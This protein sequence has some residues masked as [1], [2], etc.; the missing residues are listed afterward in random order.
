MLR[1]SSGLWGSRVMIQALHAA[2]AMSASCFE[3]PCSSSF[4]LSRDVITS[5]NSPIGQLCRLFV[6]FESGQS[7]LDLI[8]VPFWRPD[9]LGVATHTARSRPLPRLVA[10]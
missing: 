8:L 2:S 7:G 1:S 3:R 10:A 5:T 9:F 4:G 6:F